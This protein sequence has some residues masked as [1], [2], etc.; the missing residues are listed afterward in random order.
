MITYSAEPLPHY[1]HHRSSSACDPSFRWFNECAVHDHLVPPH[2]LFQCSHTFPLSPPQVE[3]CLIV[4]REL[5]LEVPHAESAASPASGPSEASVRTS[6]SCEGGAVSG[7]GEGE[8]GLS[9]SVSQVIAFCCSG[10]ATGPLKTA[11][12]E[13][14]PTRTS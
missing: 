1:F 9:L 10:R 11:T 13:W 6:P 8:G 4:A 7:E 2:G 14:K 12:A 5:G 3:L